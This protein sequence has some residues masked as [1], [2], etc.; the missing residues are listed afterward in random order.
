MNGAE[1]LDRRVRQT[2]AAARSPEVGT[3]AEGSEHVLARTG[4][5][6][7]DALRA[8]GA[9]VEIESRKLEGRHQ[10]LVRRDQL[11]WVAGKAVGAEEH[12]A[13]PSEVATMTMLNGAS[14]PCR[15]MA[16][17][18]ASVR[19]RRKAGCSKVVMTKWRETAAT[20][21]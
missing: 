6:H 7:D 16:V 2:G 8:R 5:Q 9:H 12:Q 20:G 4:V 18:P 11:G 10:P 21:C 3:R 14:W 13:S 19:I 1:V 15:S 17:N